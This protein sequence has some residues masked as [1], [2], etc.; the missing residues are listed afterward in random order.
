MGHGLTATLMGGRFDSMDM[1]YEA[2]G[3]AHY[4][5]Q[6]GWLHRFETAAVAAGGLIGPAVL[7]AILFLCARSPGWS[8]AALFALAASAGAALATLVPWDLF[9]IAFVGGLG[10]ICLASALF[11]P[12][13]LARAVTAFLAA[14]LA[15]TVYTRG[16]YLFT[17]TANGAGPS[18]VAQISEQLLLP[19]W[20]WGGG[21]AALSGGILLLG[22]IG[23]LRK[24]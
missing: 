5:L 9:D 21:I 13:T 18:D 2:G 17:E 8:R 1:N 19:Y 20:F 6:D 22:V 16:D 23:L 12:K 7:A 11:V 14:Q 10:A 3:V 24:A 4:A 15:L